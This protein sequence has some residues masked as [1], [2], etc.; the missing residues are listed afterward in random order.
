MT[1]IESSVG[2]SVHGPY[3]LCEHTDANCPNINIEEITPVVEI[4]DRKEKAESKFF[5]QEPTL[6]KTLA[7]LKEIEPSK[8]KIIIY[9]GVHPNEGTDM[10]TAQ[11]ASEW[12]EKYGATIVCQPTEDTPHAI[13]ARHGIET[14]KD[15][16]IPLSANTVLD[17]EGYADKFTLGSKDTFIIRLHGTPLSF[18]HNRQKP[19]LGVITSRYA[20]HPEDFSGR[21][22]VAEYNHPK[23]TEGLEDVLATTNQ[24]ETENHVSEETEQKNAQFYENT[25]NRLLVEYFYKDEP[26]KI[27]DPYIQELIRKMDSENTGGV[28]PLSET[29]WQRQLKMGLEYIDQPTPSDEAVADFDNFVVKDLEKILKYI[30]TK[31]PNP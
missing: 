28:F 9:A 5:I 29:N 12:A 2:C 10:L 24:A 8:R 11:Y 14:N 4:A 20:K 17:E 13:W 16:S 6:E 18:T 22:H 3:S 26:V 1:E 23:I 30:S 25:A 31:L 19:G 15:T 21:P 27:E 7:R